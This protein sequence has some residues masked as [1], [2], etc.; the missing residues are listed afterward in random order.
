MVVP[1]RALRLSRT[2]QSPKPYIGVALLLMAACTSAAPTA[3]ILPPANNCIVAAI[4]L[5]D[6][7]S[8]PL[9]AANPFGGVITGY[10]W[11]FGDGNLGSGSTTSH[12]Y[13]TPGVYPVILDVT[14]NQGCKSNAT[15]SLRVGPQPIVDFIWSGHWYK[16]LTN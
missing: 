16:S 9:P 14:T 3:A 13:A 1:F 7:S 15:L 5:N 12:N 10:S 2:R 6:N 8:M 11:N 4:V